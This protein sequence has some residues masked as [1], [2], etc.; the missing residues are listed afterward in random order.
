M[1][2]SN[3]N[4]TALAFITDVDLAAGITAPS[5]QDEFAET[6]FRTTDSD[7]DGVVDTIAVLWDV[8]TVLA[9]EDV[10]VLALVDDKVLKYGPYTIHCFEPNSGEID[11]YAGDVGK[12]DVSL[13]LIGSDSELQDSAFLE[14]PLGISG[15]ND[16][17]ADSALDRDGDGKYDVLAVDVGINVIRSG[18]Y[19]ILGSLYDEEGN[20][21]ST[22][23]SSCQ[24]AEGAR[25]LQLL[26]DGQEIHS[27]GLNGPYVLRYLEL[28]E[29]GRKLIGH[30]DQPY[31]TATYDF[32]EFEASPA[33]V[34]CS[35]ITPSEILLYDAFNVTMTINNPS[36]HILTS[37]GASLTL[38]SEFD[39]RD[40]ALVNVGDL[41]PGQT[42]QVSWIVEGVNP[43]YGE[44]AVSITSPD[45]EDVS[46]TSGVIVA[47][48]SLTESTSKYVY[49]QGD[50]VVMVTSLTNDNPEICYLDLLADVAVQGPSIEE[51]HS[52]PINYITSL[53]T[54]NFALTWDSAGQSP[55]DYTVTAKILDESRVLS[56]TSTSFVLLSSNQPPIADAGPD[57][58]V[59]AIPPATT[60]MVT[61][62]GSASHDPDGDPLTY[63]WTWDGN[64]AHGV[65]PTVELPLGATTITLVVND[66]T[67][68][69]EPDT[70]D[71]T[72]LL[73]A[74]IDFD[75]D[76]L[77]LRS[78]D[79]YVTVYIELPPGF[80]VGQIDI[81]RIRLN[82]TIP[83]LAKPTQV[84]NYDRD[85]TPDL[86]VK[87]SRSALKSLL[88]PGSQVITITGQ[89]AEIGF[90]GTD[91]IRVIG[92]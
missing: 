54:R 74:T 67:V 42:K 72:V 20:L 11:F 58:K 73:Q 61:L 48:F 80:D 76:V 75:P 88:T 3:G 36:S 29:Y 5:V 10:S 43:G 63:N 30:R 24:C 44:I 69:S 13:Y 56:E 39:T 31:V 52:I 27:S 51:R 57:Q 47:H 82:N 55:G 35:L 21:V 68:D 34:N 9:E 86:M 28:Y 26:F 71:V 77:S 66:G 78:T 64:I 22:T 18:H 49:V 6:G 81:S 89:V 14:V 46:A 33:V 70:V 59:F 38:A 45:I 23:S 7:A 8:S 60:A 19:T 91:T 62:D 4:P 92:S 25:T 83:A 15:F 53:E 32:A 90:E 1:F 84:G 79:K 41:E 65:S 17:Y 37:L 50:N 87:F 16:N 40:P 85:D 12:Y 2:D